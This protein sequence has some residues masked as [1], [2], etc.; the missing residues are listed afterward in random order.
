VK[1]PFLLETM[2]ETPDDLDFRA[3][4]QQEHG[5]GVMDLV[6]ACYRCDACGRDI[7]DP[8]LRTVGAIEYGE[9]GQLMRQA[10]RIARAVASDRPRSAQLVAGIR[11]YSMWTTMPTTPAASEIL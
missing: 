11:R 2:T 9:V 1:T 8:A 7:L 6:R 5:A 4:T 10:E 3:R